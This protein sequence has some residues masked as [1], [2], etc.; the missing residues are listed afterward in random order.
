MK[1]RLVLRMSVLIIALCL[2]PQQAAALALEA[3]V[4]YWRQDPSGDIQF[5]GDRLDLEDDFEYD[6]EEKPFGRIKLDLPAIF[7]NLYFMASPLSFE[8]T[9][10]R[11]VAFNFGDQTFTAGVPFHSEVKLDHYDIALFYSLP[12]LKK[13]TL[14]TLNA[15]LGLNVRII[16]FEAE[17]AQDLTNTSA[18]KS[19]ILPVPMGYAGF[20]LKLF[21][22][23]SLEGEV[24]G[25]AFRSSHYVDVIGRLKI[26]VIGPVFVAPGYRYEDVKID[27]Q[28]V[29][30]SLQ[31]QGP[32]VEV[33]VR[34]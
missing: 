19:F 25:I 1:K 21:K 6:P 12:F 5:K 4:G 7:P 34:F 29:D 26:H 8:E 17:V 9:A 2:V 14:D 24:R 16:D 28:D 10:T 33:G 27:H 11:N 15:E 31:L 3:A 13:A 30:A 18:S 32:F 20:Q 22:A 23:V